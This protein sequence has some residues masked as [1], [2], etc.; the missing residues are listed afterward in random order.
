MRKIAKLLC[1]I[2]SLLLVVTGMQIPA[3][4]SYAEEDKP[5]Q[6]IVDVKGTKGE[7]ELK[8]IIVDDT[9]HALNSSTIT[10]TDTITF[11]KAIDLNYVYTTNTGFTQGDYIKFEVP[12]AFK[13]HITNSTTWMEVGNVPGETPC[14]IYYKKNSQYAYVVFGSSTSN[15][16]G[17][18]AMSLK[19]GKLGAGETPVFVREP[20]TGTAISFKIRD[21]S[22]TG[23]FGQW[24]LTGHLIYKSGELIK[25]V[26]DNDSIKWS[27]LFNDDLLLKHFEKTWEKKQNGDLLSTYPYISPTVYREHEIIEDKLL[28]EFNIHEIKLSAEIRV[29][30]YNDIQFPSIS[31]IRQY[32]FSNVTRYTKDDVL[33]DIGNPNA[34]YEDFK[35][36]FRL[37]QSNTLQSPRLVVYKNND[38]QAVLLGIDSI[39]STNLVI[40]KTRFETM[41]AGYTDTSKISEAQKEMMK[42]A[43]SNA[44]AVN[45]R[46]HIITDIPDP[47]MVSGEYFQNTATMK[48][49][50]MHLFDKPKESTGDLVY[51]FKGSSYGSPRTI[52][53]E[54]KWN[55]DKFSDWG[56]NHT[57]PINITLEGGGITK[58]AQLTKDN[59]YKYEF[60]GLPKTMNSKPIVYTITEDDSHGDFKFERLETNNV[61]P[62]LV[63]KIILHNKPKTTSVNVK[64]KF[65][66]TT[67]YSDT[68]VF[69]SLYSNLDNSDGLVKDEFFNTGKIITL[70]ASNDF[71]GSFDNLRKYDISGQPI[72][73]KVVETSILNSGGEDILSNFDTVVMGTQSLGFTVMNIDKE[74][75]DIN[76]KKVWKDTNVT[77]DV[78]LNI[79]ADGNTI[80]QITLNNSNNYEYTFRGFKRFSETDGHEIKYSIQEEDIADFTASYSGDM[81]N[82]LVVENALTTPVSLKVTKVWQ[83]ING[84]PMPTSYNANFN[85]V[86][87]G[88]NT[89]YMLTTN[90]GNSLT[91]Q[92][93]NLPKYKEGK[94]IVYSLLEQDVKKGYEVKINKEEK[95]DSYEFVAVNK[96][97]GTNVNIKKVF[98]GDKL[99]E[100]TV[101]LY[102]NGKVIK[103]FTLNESNNFEVNYFTEKYDEA[104]NLRVFEVKE[105]V[106]PKYKVEYSTTGE[107][108]FVITN[109]KIVEKDVPNGGPGGGGPS[110][111]PKPDPKPDNDKPEK[112]SNQDRTP[113]PKTD[114][115]DPKPKDDGGG[116]GGTGGEDP[117]PSKPSERPTRTPDSDPSTPPT[118]S[119]P[120]YP[121]NNIPDP[122]DP[123][124]P[125]TIVVVDENGVP[126][127]T[128]TKRTN[129]DGTVEYV[130]EDGVPLGGVLV[131]TGNEFPENA[132]IITSMVSLLGLVILRRY[133]RKDK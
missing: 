92:V 19:Q 22:S 36:H 60:K 26:N 71:K 122:N 51:G 101:H 37:N 45:F 42:L 73:Y 104:G 106:Y 58:T 48:F 87:D 84:N 109:T 14:K 17:E 11:K 23:L 117:T 115:P 59:N 21:I 123:N 2:L 81:T 80:G 28:P 54:K 118:P 116:I 3:K 107:N 78:I 121:R 82:R 32:E 114:K 27:I 113:K 64:K 1:F 85:V 128:Y 63:T 20:K 124:S 83:D 126:L 131:K 4:Y 43:Y 125:E 86:A 10:G 39:P 119:V 90:D 129:P 44:Q 77:T 6:A 127:G 47:K 7:L 130:D 74:L 97:I 41:L 52:T 65:I 95:Q 69:V 76:V 62:E 96:R 40:D 99:P 79:K 112:P 49:D 9:P 25:R 46:L 111:K 15:G 98:V 66:S 133:R 110:D 88:V 34:S 24:K 55:D 13:E 100:V 67:D 57:E 93:N 35:E 29:P 91:A 18:F 53:V 8:R 120:S 30:V 68:S 103:D 72:T 75:R 89:S 61:K 5:T 105:D 33:N 16:G 108:Q 31:P 70:D 56:D 94:K 38:F 102:E 12:E 50:D 132:L